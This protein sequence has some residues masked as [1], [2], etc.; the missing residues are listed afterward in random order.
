MLICVRQLEPQ[1]FH[2]DVEAGRRSLF[3]GLA[4]SGWHTYAHYIR[5][6]VL[7]RQRQL[8][9]AKAAGL[10]LAA[11]GPSPGFKDLKWLKPVLAGDTISYRIKTTEKRD[12]KSRPN[13]GLLISQGQ[14]RNQKGELVFAYTGM[15]IVERR[16]PL[17]A[18]V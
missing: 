4:A 13:R 10:P 11:Y 15:I 17:A 1:P 5:A 12:M 2:L 7:D 9:E 3:G 16:T 14:G 18:A 8:A 6:V